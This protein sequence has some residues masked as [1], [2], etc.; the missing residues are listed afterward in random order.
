M[1]DVRD[2]LGMQGRG[3]AAPRPSKAMAKKPEGVSREA[4]ALIG[5]RD[6]VNAPLV[7]ADAAL[8]EK[9]FSGRVSRWAWRPFTSSARSDGL[10]LHHWVTA[11]DKSTDHKF[12]RFNRPIRVPTYTD[13]E[14]ETHLKDAEWS[15]EA[16]DTLVELCLQFELR[17]PAVHDR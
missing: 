16:T 12:A 1:G 9:R 5:S 11:S 15:K 4:W 6:Q 10:V 8:K 13:E 3:A 2:I 7:P 17:F 14:Y